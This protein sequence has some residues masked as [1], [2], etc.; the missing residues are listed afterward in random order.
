M[1]VDVKL[2]SENDE[3]QI[4]RKAIS[5]ENFV[6]DSGL[7]PSICVPN[8]DAQWPMPDFEYLSESDD[9]LL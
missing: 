3:S 9:V 6:E 2:P 5:S 8:P 7:P 1:I 4:G